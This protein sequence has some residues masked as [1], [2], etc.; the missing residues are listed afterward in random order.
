MALKFRKPLTPGQ[1]GMSFIDFEEI[2]K[3]KPE[4]RLLRVYKRTAGRKS[5]RQR[6]RLIKLHH[7]QEIHD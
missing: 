6:V 4:K 1:R 7:T 3:S 5:E 2:T